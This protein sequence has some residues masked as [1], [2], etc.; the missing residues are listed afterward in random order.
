MQPGREADHLGTVKAPL[1]LHVFIARRLCQL[2]EL[3]F[4]FTDPTSV[5]GRSPAGIAGSKPAGGHWCL[6]VVSVVCC[7]VEVS[8]SGWSLVQRS[9]TECGVSECDHEVS[10]MR[11]PWP[12]RGCWAMKNC[13]ISM[14]IKHRTRCFFMVRVCT[15]RREPTDSSAK[16]KM[17]AR[18]M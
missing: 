7:Q 13:P 15:A 10:I 4:Y 12:T 1:A 14:F 9:S 16:N 5:C 8:A 6:S 2:H 17:G 11:R 3:L 18:F